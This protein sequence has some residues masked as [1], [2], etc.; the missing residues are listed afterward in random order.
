MRLL[1]TGPGDLKWTRSRNSQLEQQDLDIGL[2][3]LL[4]LR[5]MD[6]DPLLKKAM[7]VIGNVATRSTCH[8]AAA[9]Q[10]LVTC[11]AVGKDIAAE[12]GKHELL[13]RAKSVYAVRL[14]VCETGEGRAAIPS[15]CKPILAVP[16]QL[17]SEFEVVNS[18]SLPPCLEALMAEHYYWTSYS[19]SR[20]DAN[21]LCQAVTLEASKLEALQSYQRLAELLPT[22]RNDL[23]STRSQWLAFVK[24]QAE[25]TRELGKL[26]RKNQEESEEQHKLEI[27]LFR[28]AMNVAKEGLDDA[29]RLMQQSMVSAGSSIEQSREVSS[30]MPWLI[31]SANPR[32]AIT[33][34]LMDFGNL[35]RMLNEATVS[36][37]KTNAENAARQAMEMQS[38][39]EL[40]L[41]T[42]ETLRDTN[43]KEI[44]LVALDISLSFAC[45]PS[46][47]LA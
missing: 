40:A 21:T 42:S 27:K 24:Q 43:V 10:L 2:T 34:V 4:T 41:V 28:S 22:F 23:L 8:Q 16:R 19:N 15:T 33:Q 32:Q 20:Q 30:A 18:V 14:S 3:D 12:E 25:S 29:S 39:H 35:R 6:E 11:K 5:D 36:A 31:P 13:E 17:N 47:N 7:Q 26:Q 45:F 38:I 37:A 44:L 46:T 9:A 1:L